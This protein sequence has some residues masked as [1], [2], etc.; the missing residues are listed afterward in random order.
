MA[1]FTV[2]FCFVQ[3]VGVQF[4]TTQKLSPAMLTVLAIL[5]GVISIARSPSSAIAIISECNAEGPF[6]ET[7]LGRHHF[8]GRRYYHVIFHCHDGVSTFFIRGGGIG[9]SGFICVISSTGSL[10]AH[11]CRIG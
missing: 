11:W 1:V 2:V 3:I 4:E 7:V 9:I 6:T 8:S 10:S 5:L